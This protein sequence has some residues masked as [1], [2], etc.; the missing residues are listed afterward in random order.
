MN[1]NLGNMRW[2]A[3]DVYSHY[4]KAPKERL[5]V[6][7]FHWSCVRQIQGP[8]SHISDND[9]LQTRVVALIGEN[10]Y[11]GSALRSNVI[12]QIAQQT[13]LYGLIHVHVLVGEVAGRETS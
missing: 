4:R 11:L 2:Y 12:N 5:W 8:T 13:G 9:R 3:S 6:P 1:T 10:T 7:R